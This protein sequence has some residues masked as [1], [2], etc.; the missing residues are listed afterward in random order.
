MLGIS[1]AL[2]L[3]GPPKSVPV[4]HQTLVPKAGVTVP[5]DLKGMRPMIQAKLNG[6]TYKFIFDT[7]T[8]A[9][10]L[11]PEIVKALNLTK[12]DTSVVT[13]PASTKEIKVNRYGVNS[14]NIGGAEFKGLKATEL[15]NPVMSHFPDVAGIIGI[16]VFANCLL[17]LDLGKNQILIKNGTLPANGSTK[18]NYSGE[19]PTFTVALGK[20]QVQAHL[21]TGSTMGL[22]LHPSVAPKL[23]LA[24]QPRTVGRARTATGEFELQMAQMNGNIKLGGLD[25]ASPRLIFATPFKTANVGV[26]LLSQ[27]RITVDQKN[28]RATFAKVSGAPASEFGRHH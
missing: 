9:L 22:T 12:V 26:P 16:P 18:F 20:V 17:T 1:L 6:K 23:N 5:V 15:D 4:P 7:A 14:L 13:S 3:Q 28:N 19:L 21:D 10:I 2:A 27:M 24:E 11:K 25:F 8:S